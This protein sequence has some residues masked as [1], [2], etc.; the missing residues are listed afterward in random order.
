[1]PNLK[2]PIITIKQA[3]EYRKKILELDKRGNPLM[4]LYLHNNI[5]KEDLY[6]FWLNCIYI[7]LL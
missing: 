5:P 3:L 1:M 7:F 6:S 4:T 2:T